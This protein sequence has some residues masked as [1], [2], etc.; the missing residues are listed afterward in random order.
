[1]SPMYVW[2]PAKVT[3][4]CRAQKYFPDIPILYS[5]FNEIFSQFVYKSFQTMKRKVFVILYDLD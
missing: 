3:A 1:M 5:I 2:P 4:F